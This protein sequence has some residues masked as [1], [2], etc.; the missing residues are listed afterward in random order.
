MVTKLWDINSFDG[1]TSHMCCFA[2]ILN[3]KMI[4]AQLDVA[5]KKKKFTHRQMVEVMVMED[6]NENDNKL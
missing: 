2:H 3:A 4:L 5:C 1:K 6:L